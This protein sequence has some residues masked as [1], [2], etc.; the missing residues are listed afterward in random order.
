MWGIAIGLILKDIISFLGY[1]VIIS[2]GYFLIWFFI[3]RD[4]KNKKDK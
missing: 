1:I 2:L 4:T 3:F